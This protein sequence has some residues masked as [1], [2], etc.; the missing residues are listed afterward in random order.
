M[1]GRVGSGKSTVGNRILGEEKYKTSDGA[2]S[3]TKYFSVLESDKFKVIDSPGVDDLLI[4][5]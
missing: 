1:L 5:K 3:E 4:S 2:L